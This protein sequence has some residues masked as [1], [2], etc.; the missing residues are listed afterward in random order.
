[1]DKDRLRE[2][3]AA[4]WVLLKR[5]ADAGWGVGKARQALGLTEFRRI[6]N[7]ISALR[8]ALTIFTEGSS[9]TD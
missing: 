6:A 4:F 7:I 2:A 3:E 9:S 5:I 8:G 1:M